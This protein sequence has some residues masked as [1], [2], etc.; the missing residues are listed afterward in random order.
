MSIKTFFKKNV[1][2]PNFSAAVYLK[3]EYHCLKN[4]IYK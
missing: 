3:S 4:I 1:L 2:V